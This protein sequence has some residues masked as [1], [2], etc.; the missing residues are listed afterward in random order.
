MNNLLLNNEFKKI[1]NDKYYNIFIN[2]KILIIQGKTKEGND[3]IIDNTPIIIKRLLNLDLD[4]DKSELIWLHG[5]GPSPHFILYKMVY[6]NNSNDILQITHFIK[7]KMPKK[8]NKSLPLEC[9]FLSNVKKTNI[10]GMVTIKN[11]KL[12]KLL[13]Y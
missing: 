12:S 6:V 11:E 1:C 2:N 8:S 3:Y 13:L 9:S 7:S 5:N 10:I 4:V